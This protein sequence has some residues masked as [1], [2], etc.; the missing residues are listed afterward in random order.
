MTGSPKI[1][2]EE[3]GP[4][5][6]VIVNVCAVWYEPPFDSVTTFNCKNP[7]TGS[8]ITV[9]SRARRDDQYVQLQVCEVQFG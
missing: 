3:D 1:Y 7:I 5:G 4:D 2:V 8:R 9:E 6:E